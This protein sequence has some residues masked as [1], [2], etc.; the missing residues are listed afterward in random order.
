MASP[1]LITGGCG[2][3]GSHFV[4]AVLAKTDH[5]VINLDKLTYAGGEDNL[6]DVA[7]RFPD[8]YRLVKG[9][10]NDAPLVET[11]LEEGPTAVINFAAESHVDRSIRDA[12][13]FMRSNTLGVQALLDTIARHDPDRLIRFVQVSTDEVYGSLPLEAPDQ[14]FT[15]A[16]PL[17]PNNPYAASKA[18]ADLMVQ[19][20]HHTFGVDVVTARCCNSFGPYQHPEKLIP[21]FVT[22]L[23]LNE[24]VPVYGDGKNVRDWLNVHDQCRAILAAWQRGTSGAVYNIGGSNERS[25]LGLTQTLLEIMGMDEGMIDYVADRPGHDRRYA[26]DADRITRELGWSPRENDW[27]GALQRTVAWYRDRPDWWQRRRGA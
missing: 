27:P 12:A 26:I 17:S 18:G 3:I 21:R 8:R 13:P 19:A 1:I 25:N 5:A 20:Y 7:E 6:A 4:R 14:R 22:N 23:L 9:D 2:F 24:K 10:I 11:L 15:E 16:S